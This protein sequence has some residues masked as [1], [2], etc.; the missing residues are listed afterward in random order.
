MGKPGV[1]EGSVCSGFV[2]FGYIIFCHLVLCCML[3]CTAVSLC[4]GLMEVSGDDA[5]VDVIG[6]CGGVGVMLRYVVGEGDEACVGEGW[7][8]VVG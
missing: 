5:C 8:H 6:Q 2:A 4:D 7:M 3:D 1:D